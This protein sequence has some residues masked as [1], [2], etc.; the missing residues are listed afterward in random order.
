MGREGFIEF[1]GDLTQLGKTSPRD[2]GKVVVLVVQSHVEGE[3]IQ[4]AIIGVCF[5]WCC[6]C[7]N[8]ISWRRRLFLED[9]LKG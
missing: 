8:S 7:G 3:E 6:A 4:G 1:A 5:Y 9:V 2:R